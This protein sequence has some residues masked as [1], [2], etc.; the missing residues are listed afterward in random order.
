MP[1]VGNMIIYW[2]GHR[3]VWAFPKKV[4]KNPNELS[5]QPNGTGKL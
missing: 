1:R 5:D 3:L 2:V 4:W